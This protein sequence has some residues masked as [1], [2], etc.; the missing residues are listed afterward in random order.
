MP[1]FDRFEIDIISALSSQ[2]VAA[3]EMLEVGPLKEA[4]TKALESG[5]GVYQLYHKGTL[6]YVGKADSLKKRLAEHHEKVSG[7]KNISVADM[8]FK[9]LFVHPNWTALAPEDSLIKYYRKAG[10]GKC[11]WNGNGFGPHDPGRER[12][13]TNK[14][15]DG[16]D[17]TYPIREDWLCSWIKSSEYTAYDLLKCMKGGLPYLLRFETAA[18]KSQKPHPDHL[19]VKAKVPKDGMPVKELLKLVAKSLSGWQATVFPSHMI[20]YKEH[21]SYKHGLTIWPA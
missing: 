5:Q 16:F 6:V 3:F 11:A 1:C 7:R 21:R 19:A 8:G 14:A 2:L 12:E 10:T 9:C 20:L 15:P 18:P 4:Q 13:T 17:A